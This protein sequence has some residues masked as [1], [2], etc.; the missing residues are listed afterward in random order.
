VIALYPEPNLASAANNYYFSAP[1]PSVQNEYDG[2]VDYN[3]SASERFFV[4]YSHRTSTRPSRAICRNRPSGGLWETITLAANNIS[5]NLDSTI[6][7]T[8][9]NELR[10]GYSRVNSLLGVP[11]TVNYNAQ[12]GI[13]GIP[14]G[15]GSANDTGLTLFSPSNYAQVGT[16]NY[17]PNTN[18]FGIYQI[19][20]TFSKVLGTH[21]MKF[22]MQLMREYNFRLASRFARAT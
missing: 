4:R 22:G 15:L 5:G 16:Q 11:D 20:D 21:V 3:V 18:N 1:E 9:T 8:A 10:L 19:N 17:W 7:P 12:L 13:K 2:R 6:S 14:P